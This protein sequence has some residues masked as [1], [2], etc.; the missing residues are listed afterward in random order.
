MSNPK[1]IK[2]LMANQGILFTYT[3]GLSADVITSILH[4]ID[5]KLKLRGI[6]IRRKKNIVNIAIECLQNIHYHGVGLAEQ[7]NSHVECLIVLS[8]TAEGYGFWFANK[9]A[10]RDSNVLSERLTYLNNL[11]AEEL[12][13]EYITILNRGVLSPKGGGGLGLIRILRESGEPIQFEIE[14]TD[15]PQIFELSIYVSIP[16]STIILA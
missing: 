13:Q 6:S 4:L 5:N 7:E 11:N 16:L 12:H 8:R 9:I 2:A 15:D 10:E 3:G 1:E 14:P